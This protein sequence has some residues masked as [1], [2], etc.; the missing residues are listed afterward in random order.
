MQIQNSQRLI[1]N[2]I[3]NKYKEEVMKTAQVSDSNII[4]KEIK[5]F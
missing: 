2:T 5:Y 4:I 1:Q 3:D